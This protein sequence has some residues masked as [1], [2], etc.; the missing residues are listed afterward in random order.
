MSYRRTSAD[1]CS[2]CGSIRQNCDCRYCD[3]CGEVCSG[4]A[5]WNC[6]ALAEAA[7]ALEESPA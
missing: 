5:C 4:S 7:E 1:Y 6:D 2:N 3:D